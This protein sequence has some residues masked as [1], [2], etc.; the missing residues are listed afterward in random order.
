[1]VSCALFRVLDVS[2]YKKH[3][4]IWATKSFRKY[5]AN[6]MPLILM[7]RVAAGFEVKRLRES[8]ESR[9]GLVSAPL[10]MSKMA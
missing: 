5:R 9:P 4:Y 1:M 6:F 3:I 2:R 7:V 8:E 10:Y